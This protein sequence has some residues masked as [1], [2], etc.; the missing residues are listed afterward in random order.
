MAHKSHP[1]TVRLDY[2]DHGFVDMSAIA[3]ESSHQRIV[4]GGAG[5]LLRDDNGISPWLN[6]RIAKRLA[7]V[8]QGPVSKLALCSLDRTRKL[9]VLVYSDDGVRP[10]A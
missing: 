3:F 9:P 5:R 1:Y 6:T 8:N 4:L 2:N 10:N 7:A